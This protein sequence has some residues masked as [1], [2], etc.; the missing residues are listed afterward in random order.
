MAKRAI[1]T[2]LVRRGNGWKRAAAQE[3]RQQAPLYRRACKQGALVIYQMLPRR[4]L[5]ACRFRRWRAHFVD[6]EGT[7]RALDPAA[8]EEYVRRRSRRRAFIS[9]A[10]G[11]AIL[12]SFVVWRLCGSDF[13]VMRDA[14]N[15]F[16]SAGRHARHAGVGPCLPLARAARPAWTEQPEC[17]AA[18]VAKNLLVRAVFFAALMLG[19]LLSATTLPP[20]YRTPFQRQTRPV[21]WKTCMAR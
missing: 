4:R 21:R 16:L 11:A 2:G 20:A 5:A 3:R 9:M 19:L 17:A 15:G 6:A 13:T 1:A 10:S 18:L 7:A 12:L 8:T 14:A